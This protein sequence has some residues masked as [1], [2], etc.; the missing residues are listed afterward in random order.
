MQSKDGS[1]STGFSNVLTLLIFSFQYSTPLC[2]FPFMQGAQ[3][4][5]V[6][7]QSHGGDPTAAAG[8]ERPGDWLYQRQA[9]QDPMGAEM[10]AKVSLFFCISHCLSA[11]LPALNLPYSS[12]SLSVLPLSLFLSPSLL[13]LFSC[14][15]TASLLLRL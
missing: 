2:G 12:L 1:Y 10:D 7:P 13:L 6:H 5:H 4:C 14:A 15:C 8:C 3:T 9:Q 11:I